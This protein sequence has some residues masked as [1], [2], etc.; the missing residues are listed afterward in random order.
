MASF[1]LAQVRSR[2]PALA[3]TVELPDGKKRAPVFLNNGASCLMLKSVGSM[4]ASMPEYYGVLGRGGGPQQARAAFLMEQFNRR[5]LNFVGADPSYFTV[6]M[7]EN[8]THALNLMVHGMNLKRGDIVIGTIFSHNSLDNPFRLSPAKIVTIGLSHGG[9]RLDV[10]KLMEAIDR[11]GPRL[12]AVGIAHASNLSGAILPLKLIAAATHRANPQA[13]LLA[14]AAQT[15]AHIPIEMGDT[16]QIDIVDILVGCG[17]KAYCGPSGSGFY[18]APTDFLSHATPLVVG[19]GTVAFVSKDTGVDFIETPARMSAGTRN[20]TG[21]A[22]LMVAMEFLEANGLRDGSLHAHEVSLKRRFF[23]L[24]EQDPGEVREKLYEAGQPGCFKDSLGNILLLGMNEEDERH[25]ANWGT[26]SRSGASC[27][28]LLALDLLKVKRA[29]IPFYRD[30]GVFRHGACGQ[31]MRLL[32]LTPAAYTSPEEI[33]FAFDLLRHGNE[34]RTYSQAH[35]E[36]S[37]TSMFLRLGIKPPTLEDLAETFVKESFE[38][39]AAIKAPDEQA[40]FRACVKKELEALAA[41]LALGIDS[42][43]A[44][45]ILKRFGEQPRHFS[46]AIYVVQKLIQEGY[47]PVR[48]FSGLEEFTACFKE[49]SGVMP[50]EETPMPYHLAYAQKLLAIL[51]LS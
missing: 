18:I 20:L 22:S 12:K 32:R 29:E 3:Q 11:A 24:A 39:K 4:L 36:E 44:D 6:G 28:P 8:A 9:T 16:S 27:A 43:D 41:S 48:Q 34:R 50:Y 35:F 37:L 25:L 30:M 1:D 5:M 42:E 10:E 2:F 45:A 40:A 38:V 21:A 47:P 17:H 26:E 7:A 51:G 33:E 23:E 49:L 14:D 13:L 15:F 19:G 31:V 46:R